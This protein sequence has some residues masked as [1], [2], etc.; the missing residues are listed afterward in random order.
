MS[1]CTHKLSAPTLIHIE[2]LAADA[3]GPWTSFLLFCFPLTFLSILYFTLL[4][5]FVA[6]SPTPTTNPSPFV[7]PSDPTVSLHSH[8]SWPSFSSSFMQSSHPSLFLLVTS[9]P[10]WFAAGLLTI[11]MVDLTCD[12]YCSTISSIKRVSPTGFSLWLSGG[13][14]PDKSA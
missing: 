7:K 3:T 14:K 10:I 9:F 1:P 4:Q 11:Q 5:S 8:L 12:A 13:L 6:T 2:H